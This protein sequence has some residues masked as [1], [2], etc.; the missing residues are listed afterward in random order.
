MFKVIPEIQSLVENA[1]KSSEKLSLLSSDLVRIT[2]FKITLTIIIMRTLNDDLTIFSP[3][4]SRY[5]CHMSELKWQKAH[6][7]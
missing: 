7:V 5:P 1:S 3:L 4:D 2:F 6:L